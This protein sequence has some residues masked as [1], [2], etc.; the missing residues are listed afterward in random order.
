[1]DGYWLFYRQAS[2]GTVQWINVNNLFATSGLVKGLNKY[3]RYWFQ[4]RSF[5]KNGSL[6]MSSNELF[7]TTP[8]D[9]MYL[10]DE[11]DF[12]FKEL[13]IFKKLELLHYFRA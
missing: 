1:M 5:T 4:L 3:T 2:G 9:G 13:K 12:I 10:T 6:V 8:E 7:E 11:C